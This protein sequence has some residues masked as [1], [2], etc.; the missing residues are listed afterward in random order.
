M[1]RKRLINWKVSSLA[2]AMKSIRLKVLILDLARK[3]KLETLNLV[4]LGKTKLESFE[5]SVCYEN[6][7][8]KV[9][10][11]VMAWNHLV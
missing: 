5:L 7:H 11:L 8:W 10:S 1:L 9:L 2:F 4:W 6:L 3:T